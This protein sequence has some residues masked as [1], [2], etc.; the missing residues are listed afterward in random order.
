MKSNTRSKTAKTLGLLVGA[1]LATTMLTPVAFAADPDTI[2]KIPQT[3]MAAVWTNS[4]VATNEGT[5]G[6]LEKILDGDPQSFW[7]TQWH[8]TKSPLP[9]SFVVKLGDAPV[10]LAKLEL[11]PRQSSNG[12]G[13]ARDWDVYTSTDETCGEN[14]NFTLAKSGSFPGDTATYR[15]TREIIFKPSI[16]AKCVKFTQKTSWGGHQGNEVTSRDE[17][18]ASLAEFNAFKGE[19]PEDNAPGGT[20][21]VQPPAATIP[22]EDLITITDG[23][24]SVKMHKQFPQVV[25]WA[26]GDAK[27]NGNT[28]VPDP[29]IYMDETSY[30]VEVSEATTTENSATWDF[31]VT[32]TAVT[33]KATATVKDGIWKL[34]LHDLVDPNG[35]MHRI[36]LHTLSFVSLGADEELAT[37]TISVN[38]AVSGDRIGAAR[39]FAGGYYSYMS[40]ATSGQLSFG[41]DNNAIADNTVRYDGRTQGSN[42]KWINVFH[43]GTGRVIPGSFVWRS[44]SATVIGNDENPYV[45][46]KPTVD[47]NK[48]SVLNWQDGAIAL[49]DIRPA[50]NGADQVKNTVI[51]RI[52][53]NIVSQAT[54]PF[55]RTLDDTKRIA[56]ATD[57]LRQQV[58]LKGYQAEGHD[59]AHPDYAGNYNERAGGFTDLVTLAN[60]AQQWNALIGVHVNATESYSESKNFS[61]ELLYMPP[62]KAWGWM[63]QSYYINGPKDLGT[64]KVLERF[65]E[66]KKEA[67][68]NLNWLYID[69]YYPDGWEG[70]R[71]SDELRKQGWVIGTE[72][73][74]KM[75]E[76]SIWSHWANDENYGGTNNKGV[77]SQIFR[78]VENTRRDIF[79][80]HPILSNSNIVEFEGWTGHVNYN[81]FIRNIWDRNLPVKF[82]QQSPIMRWE[83]NSITFENGTVA[84]SDL[85]TIGGRDVPYQRVINY[86]GAVVYQGGKYLLPW[87]DGGTDRLYHW[88]VNGGASTWTLTN[89]WKNQTSLSLFKLTDQGRVKVSDVA[90][91][92]GQITLEAEAGVAY[93]LYPTSA[94]PMPKAPNWGQGS[95][96]ADP[97]FFSGT[98]NA[99][100]TTGDVSIVK[101]DRG[102]NQVAL[103]AGAASISQILGGGNL[104]AGTYNASAWIE[105]ANGAER[106]VTLT[107]TGD[108]VTATQLQA[109]QGSVPTTVVKSSRTPNATA[110][111]E[112]FR[113]Y[114]QRARVTF[115]TTGGAV[116]FKIAAGEG[117]AKVHVDDLRLVSFTSPTLPSGVEASKVVVFE[118]FENPDSGYWPY[119]TGP[120]QTGDARTQLTRRHEPYSQAGW[121]GIDANGRPREGY[122]LVDN[123]LSGNWSLMAHEENTGLVLRTAETTVAL[124][125]NH[126][127]RISFDY[128]NARANTYAFVTGYDTLD[129][130]GRIKTTHQQIFS[131]PSTANTDVT[132][133]TAQTQRFTHEL[134]V[135]ACGSYWFG[136]EKIGGGWQADLSMDNI[137]VEDLGE[138]DT[139][140]PCASLQIIPDSGFVAG[141]ASVVRTILTSAENSVASEVKHLL[142]VP[143]GWSVTAIEPVS[144]TLA[145][146]SRSMQT[147]LVTPPLSAASTTA[148][149][150]AT[151]SYDLQDGHG[152]RVLEADLDVKITNS[153]IIAGKN[154]LSDLPFVDTRNGWGPVERDTANGENNAG[155]G[156]PI[157][158]DGVTYEKGLGTHANS[159]VKFNLGGQCQSFHAVVGVDDQ[160]T[161]AGTIRFLVT[162][163]NSA[164][165]VPETEVLRHNS[166]AVTLDADITGVQELTLWVNGAGD[167]IGNDWAS[168]GDAYVVCNSVTE[169]VVPALE[170]TPDTVKPGETVTLKLTNFTAG[171][172]P[173]TLVHA[174]S[175]VKIGEVTIGTDG[176]GTYQYTVPEDYTNPEVHFGAL[177]VVAAN[178]NA[179]SA[180]VTVKKPQP[181]PNTPGPNT[182]GLQLTLLTPSVHAGEDVI[183]TGTGFTPGAQVA[184]ELHS[185]IIPLGTVVADAA[186]KV[187]FKFKVP[188]TAVAG[189]HHVV[190]VDKEKN[191]IV[192]APVTVL[193]AKGDSSKPIVTPVPPKKPGL[194]NTGSNA[195]QVGLGALFLAVLGSFAVM[196]RKRMQ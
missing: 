150:V 16:E 48:D 60:E 186:G 138:S 149:L 85:T 21:P 25:E 133:V 168:W 156:G 81:D 59:S 143:Q 131:F 91:T 155:D 118:D 41:M 106:D 63:N 32:G 192:K 113:T 147:W 53:F 182:P 47:A 128:Q 139:V 107:V 173:V 105:I 116:T 152:V 43:E 181:Q 93:V 164:V 111:D 175:G 146:K 73:A 127:Y 86:D 109:V 11:T 57:G 44:P 61:E 129:T 55:L 67:P 102:N 98:L 9:H 66:F 154:Y 157:R 142:V 124:Q 4:P 145:A 42:G 27:A 121:W 161:S 137:L 26:L 166:A 125:P 62:R 115:T 171:D 193:A 160:Q 99:Y 148:N 12:S 52:P 28:A 10:K 54:H 77:S 14:S 79:N 190:L 117:E 174:Y 135:G 51:T 165:V 24:L 38:R 153:G 195:M 177:Q 96:I 7:H 189:A 72:W 144:D 110:S 1:S 23:T 183:G 90:V 169:T 108:G 3:E 34:E 18:V 179:A 82:L 188:T 30:P 158:I 178:T 65:K 2:T 159:M 78:F 122:K 101:T 130:K 35:Q 74:D 132:P 104:P 184:V 75:P 5:N 100:Q 185:N 114:F 119:V 17:T 170:A 56:L 71:L 83:A 187:S 8:P 69:V 76:N 88:N 68:A 31:K 120:V 172:T 141:K 191:Q 103:G 194:S 6:A 180:K 87:K 97:G 36:I 94:V 22:A 95:P 45:V 151:G 134:N 49:R 29:Q 196:R 167:G 70:R 19:W 176:T 136:I 40:I 46:V 89:A 123:V 13:R 80:P 50:I 58:M 84:T 15:E 162:G 92:N 112:K 163:D 126:K 33:F 39:T 64:G 20:D 140:V 37:A